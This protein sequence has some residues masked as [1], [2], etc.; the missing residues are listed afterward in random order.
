MTTEPKGTSPPWWARPWQS[1]CLDQ[2]SVRRRHRSQRQL[3]LQEAKSSTKATRASPPQGTL[4]GQKGRE[5][6]SPV[7]TSAAHSLHLSPAVPEPDLLV[8]VAAYDDVVPTHHVVTVGHDTDGPGAWG[9]KSRAPTSKKG[10]QE[11][12]QP[13]RSRG[14]VSS[15]TRNQIPCLP[16]QSRSSP[17]S[18]GKHR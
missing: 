15:Q 3:S 13:R 9:P 10:H 6:R 16:A 2:G 11:P 1:Q 8:I 17:R 14:M 4:H 7:P 5:R 18:Q 12:A